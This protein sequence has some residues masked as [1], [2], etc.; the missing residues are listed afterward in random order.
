MLVYTSDSLPCWW[1]IATL[2][3]ALPWIEKGLALAPQDATL[4]LRKGETLVA[5]SQGK[6]ALAALAITP[7][8]GESQF[9]RG[10]AYQLLED[11]IHAQA[12]FLDAWKLGNEDPYVLY[13]LMREDK[14]LGDKAAGVEHFKLMLARFLGFG[15]D[16]IFCWGTRTSRSQR[17]LKLATEYLAAVK[18]MPDL[19]EPN[20]RLAYLAFEAGE[21]SSAEQYYRAR[22]CRKTA[23]HRSQRVP[24]RST[25]GVSATS[26]RQSNNCA[27][28]ISVDPPSGV[29]LRF[30][31]EGAGRR[32]PPAGS[33][34]CSARR[35][36]QVSR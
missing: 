32:G 27:S 17:R 11:H 24:G 7:V 31:V 8:N 20:F 33:G 18:L 23:P 2:S 28:A 30:S 29:G 4:N 13:S 9:F 12:C 25:Y 19:F 26:R 36:Q 15:L 6:E 5:L 34:G 14:D 1:P 3:H 22:S 21:Y 35:R 10:L 16:Y